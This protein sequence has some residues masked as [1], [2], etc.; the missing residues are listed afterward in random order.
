M[1][2]KAMGYAVAGLWDAAVMCV[3][4]ASWTRVSPGYLG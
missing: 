2:S 3:F 4:Q 1:Q